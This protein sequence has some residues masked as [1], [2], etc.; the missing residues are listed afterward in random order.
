MQ[1][2]LPKNKFSLLSGIWVILDSRS[3]TC[4]MLSFSRWAREPH[5]TAIGQSCNFKRDSMALH[6]IYLIVMMRVFKAC[7]DIINTYLLYTGICLNTYKCKNVY[8]SKEDKHN[9]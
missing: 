5:T 3:L 4:A 7:S 2:T 1:R 9:K 8:K 6:C